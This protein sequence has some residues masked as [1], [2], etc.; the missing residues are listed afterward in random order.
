MSFCL[1]VFWQIDVKF[2]FFSCQTIFFLC[3][4]TNQK[5]FIENYN[6]VCSKYFWDLTIFMA[7]DL[8]I[9]C[10]FVLGHNISSWGN[11]WQPWKVNFHRLICQL[12]ASCSCHL[13]LHDSFQVFWLFS[14]CP[15]NEMLNRGFTW[16]QVYTECTRKL[17]IHYMGAIKKK[18]KK[19]SSLSERELLLIYLFFP[20]G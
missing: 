6:I 18:K 1:K 5:G 20:P 10:L 9:S 17:L 15:C 3:R 7:V 4:F 12:F 11:I 13:W 14:H 19:S 2:I 8:N 16:E